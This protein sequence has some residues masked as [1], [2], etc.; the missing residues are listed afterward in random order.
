[1]TPEL[2]ERELQKV[3]RRVRVLIN[4]LKPGERPR[5]VRQ[6]RSLGLSRMELLQQGK[7]YNF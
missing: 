2:L 6:L 7:T 4:H 1:M 5:I 3:T